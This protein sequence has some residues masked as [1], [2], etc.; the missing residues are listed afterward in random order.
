MIECITLNPSNYGQGL[1]CVQK[2]KT[3]FSR[4]SSMDKTSLTP[5][6]VKNIFY[7]MDTTNL[8]Q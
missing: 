2:N 8:V 5:T 7:V 4:P 1:R 3:T 6:T